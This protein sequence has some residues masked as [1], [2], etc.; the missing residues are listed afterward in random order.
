MT[1]PVPSKPFDRVHAVCVRLRDQPCK[2]CPATFDDERYGKMIHGCYA[3]AAEAVNIAVHGDPW[4]GGASEETV[5][6]W[7][8][9]FNRE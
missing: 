6:A 3:L 8:E 2:L 1:D 4:G 7:R 9:R 5:K